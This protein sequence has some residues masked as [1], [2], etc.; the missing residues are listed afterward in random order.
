MSVNPSKIGGS[1]NAYALI[2][3]RYPWRWLDAWG[4]IEKA[5]VDSTWRAAEFTV[6][7]TGTSPVTASVVPG[8][9]ALITS[10]GNDFDGDN[11]QL[12]GSRFK[13]D[14]GKPCYFGAELTLNEATQ[15]DLIVGLFGVD[16]AL[17]A[18]SSAHALDVTAG[19]VGFTKLDNVTAL[20][21]KTYTATAE[22]NSAS[23]ATFTTAKHTFEVYFDGATVSMYYDAVKVACFSVDITTEVL[24]PSLAFRTGSAAAKTCTLHWMRAFQVRS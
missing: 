22:K 6:T 9:V 10:G 8:A 12:V 19:G 16:T 3:S 13:L 14:A 7:A 5:I 4:D 15:S 1:E 11:V 24:T 17:C 23:I 18:A 21:A 20:L 2:D